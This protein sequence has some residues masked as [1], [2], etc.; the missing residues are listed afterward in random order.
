MTTVYFGPWVGEFGWELLHWSAWI[1]KL[2]QLDFAGAKIVVSSFPGR[3]PLYGPA[4]T[5][6]WPH[7]ES[8]S[9]QSVSGHGYYT[10]CWRGGYPGKQNNMRKEFNPTT[11]KADWRFEEEPI[12]GADVEKTAWELLNRHKKLLPN[13]TIFFTPW[14]LNHYKPDQLSFGIDLSPDVLPKSCVCKVLRIPYSKQ[15][16]QTLEPSPE[17]RT[18]IDR[19]IPG[20]VNFISLLPRERLVRRSDKNWQRDKY[21]Q[22]VTALQLRYPD[23]PVAIL[24]EPG[25]AYFADGVPSGCLDLINVPPEVRLD[26]QLAILKRSVMALGGISGALEVPLAAGC[27]TLIWG[28]EEHQEGYHE[29]NRLLSPLSYH[30]N[31]NPTVE[32]VMILAEGLLQACRHIPRNN[33]APIATEAER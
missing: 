2:S 20:P 22:L 23:Y 18:E 13:D 32:T 21:S 5:E 3:Y 28:I 31:P 10:D 17:V 26:M 16:F 4:I 7:P 1:R 9:A 15:L 11:G 27:P 6:F 8:L 30:G 33:V 19:A 14:L 24:G 25:G 29:A 12:V